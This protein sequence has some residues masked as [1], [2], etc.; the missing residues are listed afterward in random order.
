MTDPELR[1][2]KAEWVTLPGAVPGMRHFHIADTHG[3]NTVT[4]M[5]LTE[6]Q[7][8]FVKEEIGR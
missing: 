8:K 7:A 1:D 4:E 5:W 2:I 6:R 3:D